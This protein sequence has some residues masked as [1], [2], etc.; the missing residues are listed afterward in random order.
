MHMNIISTINNFSL[1]WTQ[2][3]MSQEHETWFCDNPNY[4]TAFEINCMRHVHGY[5]FDI[6]NSRYYQK[7]ML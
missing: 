1:I 7:R 2:E 5:E 4:V 6:S 3:L